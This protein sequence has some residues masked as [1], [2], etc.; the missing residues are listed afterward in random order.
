MSHNESEESG[1]IRGCTRMESIYHSS[2][3]PIMKEEVTTQIMG[4]QHRLRGS[5]STSIRPMREIEALLAEVLMFKGM[6][7]GNVDTTLGFEVMELVCGVR[8]T[9]DEGFKT[10]LG[11]G[12]WEDREE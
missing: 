12:N 1:P 7:V 11:W 10:E 3:E 2:K 4:D 6:G 8:V 5:G 9:A